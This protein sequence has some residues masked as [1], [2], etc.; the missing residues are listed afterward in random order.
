MRVSSA[1]RLRHRP[2][3]AGSSVTPAVAGA[4]NRSTNRLVIN[5]S[6]ANVSMD[7][8]KNQM[9]GTKANASSSNKS[10]GSIAK[11]ANAK[12]PAT[13]TPKKTSKKAISKK[14]T[15]GTSKAAK[16]SKASLVKAIKAREGKSAPGTAEKGGVFT[17]EVNF[18]SGAASPVKFRGCDCVAALDWIFR[19]I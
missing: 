3:E 14:S 16:P 12:Q 19:W 5:K 10:G 15:R 13:S 2:A 4:K 11:K 9:S 1:R 18:G 8:Q 7:R 6:S 17:N